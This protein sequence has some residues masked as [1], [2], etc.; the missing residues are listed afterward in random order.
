MPAATNATKD[1]LKRTEGCLK[2]SVIALVQNAE[3]FKRISGGILFSEIVVEYSASFEK[4]FYVEKCATR[5]GIRIVH[6][7]IE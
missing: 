2:E 5:S 1:L 7:Y 3:R 6:S 4:E